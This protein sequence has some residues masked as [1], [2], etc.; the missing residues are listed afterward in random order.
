M[1][2]HLLVADRQ[3]SIL[4]GF[5]PHAQAYSP[6]GV[7]GDGPATALAFSGQRRDPLVGG[8]P[9][10]N[11]RRFYSPSLMRFLAPDALSP[12]SKGG[13][14]GYVYCGADPVNRHDPSGAFWVSLLLRVIGMAS[15]GATL[16]G[17]TMRTARNVVS[18]RA[19]G[20]A[21]ASGAASGVASAIPSHQELPHAARV[22]NQMFALTGTAG[23]ATHAALMASGVPAGISTLSEGFGFVNTVSN[24]SGGLAG[25]AAAAREVANYLLVNPGEA[26]GV[27]LETFM[28]VTMLDEMLAAGGRGLAG[29]SRRIRSS[30]PQIYDTQV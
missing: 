7:V 19:A 11:G 18:R 17:A 14:N 2:T 20:R 5:P 12:F 29:L 10:G 27:A 28:D 9:L 3:C 21:G 16:F 15:S 13:I 23:V 8:Y 4:G 22:S 26:G 6:Y 24:L 30:R 1:A 25:S